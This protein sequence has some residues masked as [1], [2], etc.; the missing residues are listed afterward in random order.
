MSQLAGPATQSTALASNRRLVLDVLLRGGEMTRQEISEASGLS[1]AATARITS[2]LDR[3]KLI[4]KTTKVTDTGGRPAWR[5]RFTA[6]GRFLIGA[7]MR[8]DGCRGVLI[9]WDGNVLDRVEVLLDPGTATG[10]DTLAATRECVSGL[11]QK[12]LE[13]GGRPVAVGVSVPAI[14]DK[15]GLVPRGNYFGWAD[16]PIREILEEDSGV[17]VHA[18]NDANALVMSELEP[19]YSPDSLIAFVFDTGFGSGV[20]CNGRLVRGANSRAGEFD[21]FHSLVRLSGSENVKI[22]DLISE[23]KDIMLTDVGKQV[24]LP[25]RLWQRSER[26]GDRF[27][28]AADRLLNFLVIGIESAVALIDP[29]RIVIGDI[30]P[31]YVD[32]FTEELLSRLQGLGTRR[33]PIQVPRRGV[34]AVVIGAARLASRLVDL[35]SL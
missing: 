34:D 8:M 22:E 31:E 6:E 19:G 18:E 2:A 30:P 28:V 20:V 15:M 14:V 13:R 10:D 4:S 1:P 27:D 35:Q 5:Y 11:V 33:P 7:R 32:R 12:G 29:E 9:T 23:F 26:P 21:H 17:P 3:E 24:A 16:V 25:V